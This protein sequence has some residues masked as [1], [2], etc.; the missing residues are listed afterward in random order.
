MDD[1]NKNMRQLDGCNLL[2]ETDIMVYQIFVCYAQ[3]AGIAK[4]SF[5]SVKGKKE[6][7]GW[8]SSDFKCHRAVRI[9]HSDESKTRYVLQAQ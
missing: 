3:N 5:V 1:E 4:G 8:C 2:F 6:D 9:C 7:T